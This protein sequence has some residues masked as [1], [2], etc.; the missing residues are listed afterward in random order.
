MDAIVAWGDE[1]AL[2]DRV[3]AHL[4]EQDHVGVLAQ[5]APH[6]LGERRDVRNNFV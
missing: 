6:R 1:D 3:E 2:V 5:R 4:A